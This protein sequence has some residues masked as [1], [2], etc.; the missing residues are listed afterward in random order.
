[1]FVIGGN[2]AGG[3]HGAYPSLT[4]LTQGDLKM[5]V[6]VRSVYAAVLEK[7]LSIP[8][9]GILGGTFAPVGIFN[10]PVNCNPRP[11]VRLSTSVSGGRLQVSLQAGGG[12]IRQVRFGPTQNA[13]VDVGTLANQTGS[14]SYA[15]SPASA[16]VAFS[17]RRQAAGASTVPIVLVDDCGEWRSFVG[18]GAS[19]GF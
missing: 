5:S 7:W 10:E 4:D 9:S 1:M 12:M 18:G 16:T 6:D 8:S 14:F 3:L 19:V 13:I 11:P 15:P 2:V 17:V